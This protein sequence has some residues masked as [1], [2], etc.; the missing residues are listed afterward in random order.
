MKDLTDIIFLNDGSCFH[1]Y[2][3]LT[4]MLLRSQ[5]EITISQQHVDI[6]DHTELDS[7]DF[8]LRCRADNMAT[9]Q[10]TMEVVAQ[11]I[12]TGYFMECKVKSPVT[13]RMVDGLK[14]IM[15]G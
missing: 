13:G 10:A 2:E 4:N 9:C 11:F 6:F 15:L 14:V 7:L 5:T 1:V 8:W 12:D 3:L